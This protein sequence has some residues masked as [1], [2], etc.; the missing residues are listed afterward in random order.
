MMAGSKEDVMLDVG[1]PDPVE[2][3]KKTL[4]DVVNVNS[5]FTI[6]VFVGLSF[7]ASKESSLESREDCNADINTA[8]RLVVFEV[9]SFSLFLC[10]SLVAK[11]LKFYLNCHTKEEL[12]QTFRKNV[13]EGMLVLSLVS[14]FSGMVFLVLSMINVIQIKLGKI[15]CGI[16][17]ALW[18]A[19]PMIVIVGLA[20]L[21]YIFVVGYCIIKTRKFI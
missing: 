4:D 2:I 5:L 19:I 8:K 14:S 21:I 20:L 10:S 11:T 3:F 7:S 12:K 1:Q 9:V 17:A 6:A 13:R 15:S 16:Q 18:A